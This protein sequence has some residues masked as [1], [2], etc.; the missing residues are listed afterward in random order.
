MLRED[1]GDIV[2][3]LDPDTGDD[4]VSY[5]EEDLE[6]AY[7]DGAEAVNELYDEPPRA[8]ELWF[9][10]DGVDW[11]RLE[12]PAV[13]S[14][15]TETSNSYVQLAAVGD[16]EVLVTVTTWLTPP[17]ELYAFEEEGREPTDAEVAALDEWFAS[18]DGGNQVEWYRIPIG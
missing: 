4:L 16:D 6:R 13:E 10:G 12:S 11:R 7:V 3:F 9:T 17:P 1:A 15:A 8:R 5:S 14:T 2:T 18:S